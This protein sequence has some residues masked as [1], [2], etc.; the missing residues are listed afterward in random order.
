MEGR[1]RPATRPHASEVSA[2]QRSHEPGLRPRRPAP[3]PHSLLTRSPWQTGLPQER[4]P[5]DT[6]SRA[7]NL[8]Q[9]RLAA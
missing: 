9:K 4:P 8:P 5:A 3:A 1:Q 6:E 2:L 7:V